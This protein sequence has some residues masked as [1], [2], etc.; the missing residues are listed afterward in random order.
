MAPRGL[1]SRKLWLL[2]AS[3]SEMRTE[4]LAADLGQWEK[5]VSSRPRPAPSLKHLPGT[6]SLTK[7]VLCRA[8]RVL[9]ALEVTGA[10]RLSA[11]MLAQTGARP[12][13]RDCCRQGHRRLWV[14]PRARAEDGAN[15]LG[16]SLLCYAQLRPVNHNT[17]V[18]PLPTAALHMGVQTRADPAKDV[19]QCL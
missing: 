14:R 19:C 10:C 9:A 17:R 15:R 18:L 12:P 7:R 2:N 4:L 1:C 8:Q 16:K 6:F 13:R 11:T 3:S 5:L